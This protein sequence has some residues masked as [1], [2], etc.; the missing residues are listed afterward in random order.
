ML[1]FLRHVRGFG[2]ESD[3]FTA[4]PFHAEGEEWTM[5]TIVLASRRLAATYCGAVVALTIASTPA[6]AQ[7]LCGDVVTGIGTMTADIVG[8]AVN[9]AVIVDGGTLRMDGF[10]IEA[11]TADGIHVIG[12]AGRVEEG[13]V[14][15]CV[16]GIVLDGNGSH[17]IE[18]VRVDQNSGAAFLVNVSSNRFEYVSSSNN[19]VGWDFAVGADNNDVKYSVSSGDTTAAIVDGDGN[20]FRDTLISASSLGVILGGDSNEFRDSALIETS[21]NVTGNDNRVRY[22]YSVG[23]NSA[24]GF[25]FAGDSNK[26]ERSCIVNHDAGVLLNGDDNELDR[27]TVTDSTSSS[28][29]I[30]GTNNDVERNFITTGG[31]AAA[32]S[33]GVEATPAAVGNNVRNNTVV[34]HGIFDLSDADATCINNNFTSNVEGSK[35]PLCLN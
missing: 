22:G 14:S 28:V 11:C 12:T 4:L 5:K 9:P 19:A 3:T 31:S 20:D 15:N 1:E 27:S 30:N 18:Y 21:V 6:G 29:N 34:G 35:D 10:M 8:C 32:G 26:V 16:N 17:R 33:Y 24:P 7:V 23:D 25:E 2:N 13:R